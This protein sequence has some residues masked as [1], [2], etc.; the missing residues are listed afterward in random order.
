MKKE[1]NELIGPEVDGMWVDDP[2]I[3]KGQVNNYM[4][5]RLAT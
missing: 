4:K 1:R 5:N 3:V 2:H